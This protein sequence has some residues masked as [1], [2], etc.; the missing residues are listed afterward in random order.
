MSVEV[1]RGRGRWVLLATVLGSAMAMVDATAVNVALPAI[2]R[3]F[4]ASV[5]GLQWTVNGYALTLAAFVLV[6]GSLGDRYGRRRVFLTGVVWFGAASLLC[7]VAPSTPA[8][9][10]ARA[11][12]GV[13]AALLTPGS[14]A[15]IQASFPRDDR[16]RAIGT[17]SA[18][19]GIAAAVGPL[20]GGYL[21]DAVSWRAVFLLNLPLSAVVVVVALRYVPESRDPYVPDR[22]DVSGALAGVI[23]LAGVTYALIESAERGIG[24]TPVAGAALAGGVGLVAFVTVERRSGHPMVPVGIFGR[25]QFA[26]ANLLTFVVYAGLSGVFFFLAVHLQGSLGYSPIEAG[27]AAL[28]VT[29]SMLLLSPTAGDVAQRIGPR[30]PL[31][32]GPLGIAAGMLLMLRI[33]PGAGYLATVLPAVVVFGLGLSATVA[34]VTATVLAAADERHAGV[35]SAVNNAVARLAGLLAVA[36]LPS[37]AGLTGASFTDPSALTDGFRVAMTVAAMLVLIGAGIGWFAIENDVLAE[38]EPEEECDRVPR[39]HCAVDAPPPKPAHSAR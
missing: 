39:V 27:A 32:V 24:A 16:A 10:G 28:P 20:L 38:A 35:A 18:L 14:L 9:V 30:L 21:V 37:V 34:P 1:D 7:A 31:T 6:G 3:D 17:W 36:V 11:L 5:A 22:L 12:Q 4:D 19:G 8:L 26:Y 23:G 25:S 13:G 33:E 15:L 29:A 2:G